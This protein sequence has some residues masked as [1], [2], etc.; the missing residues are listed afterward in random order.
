MTL[1]NVGFNV[2][3][4]GPS[5]DRNNTK[6]EFYIIQFIK[7]YNLLGSSSGNLLPATEEYLAQELW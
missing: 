1:R 7:L 6:P 3:F 2:V 5:K 4:I